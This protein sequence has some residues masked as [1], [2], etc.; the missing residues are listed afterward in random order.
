M[1]RDV[2]F[3]YSGLRVRSL[4]RAL[5][6]YQRLGFRVRSRGVMEHGGTWVQLLYPG[7][8][9]RLELNYYPPK[10]PYYEPI[11]RG[12]EFDHLGFYAKDPLAWKRAALR[13]GARPA[14]E[15]VEGRQRIVYVKDPDGNWLEVF[16]PA[17][18]RRR[19]R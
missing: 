4:P 12:T 2:Q 18:P 5:R 11:R 10:N 19:R 6:F 14:L 9:H 1:P 7:S 13:A 8:H 15:F 17:K 16:G 3:L